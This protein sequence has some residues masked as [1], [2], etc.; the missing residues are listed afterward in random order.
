M[1]PKTYE[2]WRHCITIVCGI[3][4]TA[5]FVKDRLEALEKESSHEMKKFRARYGEGH[6]QQVKDWFARAR[7]EIGD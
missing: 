2:E 6:L 5:A 4:L 3:P 7:E 1:I